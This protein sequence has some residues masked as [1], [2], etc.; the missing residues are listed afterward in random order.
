M[1]ICLML[2]GLGEPPRDL[3]A[4]E[5]RYWTGLDS[6]AR[7]VALAKAA[8]GRILFTFD[9]GNDTDAKIAL[10]ALVAAG[11]KARFFV[12]TDF[13]GQPGH[14]GED[15]LRALHAAGMTIGSHGCQHTSWQTMAGDEVAEDVIRSFARLG[16]ILHE[17]IDEVAAPYGELG[18]RE[19]RILRRLGVRRV[20]TSFHGP[21]LDGDFL[22]RREC[23]TVDT[24]METVERWLTGDYRL[25]DAAY[26]M[27]RAARHVG[28]AALWRA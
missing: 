23:V 18:F 20:F 28:P 13:I 3:D 14:V 26:A 2:H 9:D 15:D 11:L 19:A 8:P 4:E 24:P 5:R 1:N 21:F 17:R 10:P 6:F 25:H 27:L 7:I 16:S 22:V 12:S